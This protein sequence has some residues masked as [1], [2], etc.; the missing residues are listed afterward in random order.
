MEEESVVRRGI[1]RQMRKEMWMGLLERWVS[2][3]AV[4]GAERRDDF[5]AFSLGEGCMEV[6]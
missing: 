2:R 3:G 5:A 1:E 6:L 4:A